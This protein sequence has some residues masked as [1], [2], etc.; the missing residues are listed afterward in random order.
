MDL[1]ARLRGSLPASRL[2][3]RLREAALRTLCMGR[4]GGCSTDENDKSIPMFG[5]HSTKFQ[6]PPNW[7]DSGLIAGMLASSDRGRD[8]ERAYRVMWEI[9]RGCL[10][11]D[12]APIDTRWQAIADQKP[13][14]ACKTMHVVLPPT[15]GEQET[16]SGSGGSSSS[17]ATGR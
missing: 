5:I 16:R 2:A 15:T 11:W 3:L 13:W 4:G 10:G 6:A 8:L 7:T 9:R 12:R 1:S 14:K 17:T